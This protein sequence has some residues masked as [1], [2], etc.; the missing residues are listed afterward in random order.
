MGLEEKKNR[1]IQ[2]LTSVDQGEKRLHVY[3]DFPEIANAKYGIF[4]N[5]AWD[6]KQG[7]AIFR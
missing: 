6:I 1:D 2:K 4:K 5:R 7:W 3:N